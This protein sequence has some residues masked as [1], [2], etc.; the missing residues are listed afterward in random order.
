MSSVEW[1]NEFN[2]CQK[3]Y[4]IYR[5]IIITKNQKAIYESLLKHEYS[6]FYGN[7]NFEDFIKAEKRILIIGIDDFKDYSLEDLYT[8]QFEHN[9]III[10]KEYQD[11]V[12]YTFENI[13]NSTLKK[14]YYVWII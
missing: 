12:L 5:T 2:E 4:D 1:I 7:P 6:V 14:N 9:F 11:E 3:E 10:D 13:K 8:M